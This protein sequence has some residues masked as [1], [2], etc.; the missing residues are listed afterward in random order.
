MSRIQNRVFFLFSGFGPKAN[1]KKVTERR[2]IWG[3]DFQGLLFGC[4]PQRRYTGGKATEIVVSFTYCSGR[5]KTE[6][7]KSQEHRK[8]TTPDS[9]VPRLGSSPPVR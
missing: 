6:N 5:A 4:D 2:K 8:I 1:N 7:N 9:D 3:I